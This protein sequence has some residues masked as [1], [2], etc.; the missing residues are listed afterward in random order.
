MVVRHDGSAIAPDELFFAE[1]PPAIGEVFSAYSSA[2]KSQK[3]GRGS[4]VIVASLL[5]GVLGYIVGRIIGP[6]GGSDLSPYGITGG[7]VGLV[8]S[9]LLLRR[10]RPRRGECSYVGREGFALF[11]R[12][13]ED[14]E[15]RTLVRFAEVVDVRTETSTLNSS[16]GIV[17][18]C[19]M[20][21]KFVSQKG[22]VA[23]R[24]AGMYTPRE[25]PTDQ[26]YWFGTRAYEAWRAYHQ[27]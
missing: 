23:A 27:R 7:L 14:V 10:I 11:E 12:R 22:L 4:N 9:F 26:D 6:M 24:I 18:L 17:T 13:G 5:F 3:K 2:K 19:L 21:W 15:A 25:T 8:G 1:P 20:E 16:Y